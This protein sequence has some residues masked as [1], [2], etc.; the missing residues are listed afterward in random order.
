MR[1][2]SLAVLAVL[3][4]ASAALTTISLAGVSGADGGVEFT[5]E[6][7]SAGS[8]SLAG[9]FNNWNMNADK[10]TQDEDGVW[11]IVVDLPPGEYEYKFVVNG[12]EWIADPDNPRV[13]G[14]YGNS[15]LTINEDGEP[16]IDLAGIDLISNTPVNSRVMLNGWYRTTYTTRSDVE[17]DP[18]WRL[19]RPAHEVYLKVNPTVTDLASGSVTLYVTT[20]AGDI[21]EITADIYSGH[22]TLE[23]GP[24]TATGFYNEELVQYDNPLETVGHR[25][26]DLTIPEEH[27]A[28]GRGAQGLVFETDFWDFDLSATYAN[29]YDLKLM[30]DPGVYDNTE[31]DLLAARLKRGLGPVTLGATYTSWRDGWWIDWTGTN[32]SPDIDEYRQENPESQSD[33]FE[34]ANT[35][36]WLGV[37]A[38]MPVVAGLL[39]ASAEVALYRFDS[40]F[41][42]GNREKVEGESYSNGAIDVPVGDTDGLVGKVILEAPIQ[43]LDLRFE[44]LFRSIDA[45]SDDELYV[46]FGNPGWLAELRGQYTEVKYDGSPLSVDVYGPAPERDEM[47]IEFDAGMTFGIFDLGV[48]FDYDSYEWTYIE[49]IDGPTGAIED[50]AQSQTRFVG[51]AGVSLTERIDLGLS[52]ELLTQDYDDPD[53]KGPSRIQTI[54]T[55]D[56]GLW[57][58]WRLLLN[59]R[60]AS[61]D[62]F[63]RFNTSLPDSLDYGDGSFLA[64]YVAM[65][66]TPRE[67]VEIRVGYGVNPLSYDDTPVEG[68]PNGRERWMSGYLWEHSDLDWLDAEEA[69]ED[70]RTIG[71]MGVITF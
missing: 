28:F 6:D 18:R 33:W 4:I 46:Q 19:A 30:N 70:A 20:G 48:E 5:Y 44:A 67:N 64:P 61:Y 49:P 51:R 14:D 29:V 65:V 35:E 21:R 58:N 39:D 55:A 13:V 8:V 43:P 25:D 34:L 71:V 37:D 53:W 27:I 63:I 15:G 54:G 41:D 32:S 16:V 2:K 7:P 22:V 1:L 9:D 10:M 62:D 56:V 24:F 11:R 23:G 42:M 59:V 69:L 45:M 47:E 40:R 3:I 26:L 52:S 50:W 31:T 36:S 57:E 12:S 60:H 17:R 38:S 68:R 66:Y